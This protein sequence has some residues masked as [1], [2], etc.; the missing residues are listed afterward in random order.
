MTFQKDPEHY[1]TKNLRKLVNFSDQRV[2]EVGCGEGRLTWEYAHSAKQVVGIDPD[3]D[4]VRVANYDMPDDLRKMTTFACAS[5]LKL[6][7]PH[8]SF[9]IALLSWSF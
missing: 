1:E 3:S 2:L 6:P 7:F 5:S 8:E 4:A 9:D